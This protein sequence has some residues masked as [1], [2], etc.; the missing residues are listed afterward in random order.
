MWGYRSCDFFERAPHTF[1]LNY[2]VKGYYKNVSW[3]GTLYQRCFFLFKNFFFQSASERK[4]GFIF[5]SKKKQ[6]L[7][8]RMLLGSWVP[9]K[10]VRALV[11]SLP[12]LLPKRFCFLYHFY[13][14]NML[15][16]KCLSPPKLM[17]KFNCHC[18]K[19]GM[20]LK[21]VGI[22][23]TNA[24]KTVSLP[25]TFLPMPCEEDPCSV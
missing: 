21:V 23:R 1:Q 7:L 22:D 19:I 10:H 4:D 17:V 13:V 5:A 18:N 12:C 14:E 11:Q 9:V 24:I 25:L 2:F 8:L 6:I 20:R 3:K 16:F 15:Q